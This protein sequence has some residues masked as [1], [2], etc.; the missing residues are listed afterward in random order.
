M[1]SGRLQ[2]KPGRIFQRI[3]P[4]R[5]R[6][7]VRIGIRWVFRRWRRNLGSASA[8]L[9]GTA[10]FIVVMTMREDVKKEFGNRLDL[11]GGATIIQV[12]F[13]E[14]PLN[15][16]WAA[17]LRIFYWD[18]MTVLRTLP[19]VS[20][21]SA[22]ATAMTPVPVSRGARHNRFTLVAV[23]K[24]FWNLHSFTPVSGRFFNAMEVENGERVCVI[25]SDMARMIFDREDVAGEDLIV[26]N[27]LFRISGVLDGFRVGEGTRF[28]FVPMTTALSRISNMTLPIRVFVRC[29]N[30]EIVEETAARIPQIVGDFFP[31]DRL[32]VEVIRDNLKRVKRVATWIEVSALVSVYVA[33]ILGGIGIWNVM[34]ASVRSRTREIGLKKAVG[35]KDRDIF[36]Q[37]I[38]ESLAL[39]VGAALPGIVLGGIAMAGIGFLL[40]SH[41]PFSLFLRMAGW[42]VAFAIA[43]GVSAGLYPSI[44]ASRMEVS[45]ALRYG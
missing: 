38:T 45:S 31:T 19:G 41:P 39:C 35:G 5:I 33:L 28:I 43:L 27:E 44:E 42:S 17:E 9:L 15:T 24:D 4:P 36:V 34:T 26:E 13:E 29:R 40:D 22:V 11:L 25:G 3:F 12:S 10:G 7:I 14:K 32:R 1:F 30:W 18:M 20:I 16:P 6:D 8:V 21:V 37:F 2:I 23:D